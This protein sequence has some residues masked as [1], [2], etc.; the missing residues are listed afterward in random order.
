M[1]N[2]AKLITITCLLFTHALYANDHPS[3]NED[4]ATVLSYFSKIIELQQACHNPDA[5]DFIESLKNQAKAI[6]SVYQNRFGINQL[7]QLQAD[8][9]QSGLYTKLAQEIEVMRNSGLIKS[10]LGIFLTFEGVAGG[11]LTGALL[12]P[13]AGAVLATALVPTGM[14]L[15]GS[16]ISHGIQNL[17]AKKV[18][19]RF[20]EIAIELPKIHPSLR[21]AI[22]SHDFH[23][24][25][26]LMRSERRRISALNAQASQY[27]DKILAQT[28]F[29]GFRNKKFLKVAKGFA[30]FQEVKDTQSLIN[31]LKI[32]YLTAKSCSSD[33]LEEEDAIVQSSKAKDI[34]I[35]QLSSGNNQNSFRQ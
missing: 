30:D 11:A 8:E 10:S 20:S 31:S 19:K 21:S 1:K 34:L 24:L 6:D 17:S 7:I 14:Y 18:N 12:S 28:N 4:R 16:G 5:L 32:A 35:N 29:L 33:E 3:V 25:S 22:R 9:N 13:V 26:D 2:F 23:L 27:T 15:I